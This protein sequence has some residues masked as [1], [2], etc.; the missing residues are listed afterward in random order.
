[1]GYK[2]PIYCTD[3]TE[4]LAKIMLVDS[5]RIQEADV[6]HINKQRVRD[7]RDLIEPLYTIED[8]QNVLPLFQAVPYNKA[9]QIDKDIELLY[10][11]SG[12]ILG[13]AVSTSGYYHYGKHLWR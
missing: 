2:G 13:S 10:T 6:L 1:L 4:D 3:A 8:A 9:I 12:H 5:A 11:D 7:G